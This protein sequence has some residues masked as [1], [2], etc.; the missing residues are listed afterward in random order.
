MPE[1][2]TPAEFRARMLSLQYMRKTPKAKEKTI[3]RDDG[4]VDDGKK[5]KVVTVDDG[6]GSTITESDNRQDCDIHPMTHYETIG[7]MQ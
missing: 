4:M 5:A 6:S 3:I 7:F 1:L 2:E